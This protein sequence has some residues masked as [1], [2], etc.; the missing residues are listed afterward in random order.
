MRIKVTKEIYDCAKILFKG[1]ATLQEVASYLKLG[2]STAARIRQSETLEDYRQIQASLVANWKGNKK[3]QEEQPKEKPEEAKPEEAKPQPK[4]VSVSGQY[5][6][7]RIVEI[8]KEQN[9]ILKLLSNKIAFIV[10][11]LTK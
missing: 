6:M 2:V 1:G 4:Q 3:K 10:D 7:N 5:Q 11:E 8:L 9:E